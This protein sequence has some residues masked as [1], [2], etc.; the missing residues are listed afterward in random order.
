[1]SAP[2]TRPGRMRHRLT[3][4]SSSIATNGD[5]VWAS[6][7]TIWAAVEPLGGAERDVAGHRA[8]YA[9]HRIV[10]RYRPALTSA[11]RL[12]RA[13]RVF[14]I[15]AVFHPDEENRFTVALAEEEPR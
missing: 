12:V 9:T 13:T 2:A 4:Q 7:A 5:V 8:G 1:M 15:L 11:D 10:L 6:V 3:L 14:R